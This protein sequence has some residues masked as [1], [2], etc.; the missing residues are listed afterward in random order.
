[1]SEKNV[2]ALNVFETIC[3]MFDSMELRYEK[4]VE[5]LVVT[6][7]VT[8]DDIPMDILFAVDEEMQ[9]VRL[10]SPLPGTVPEDKRADMAIVITF[11]NNML[12]N[13]SFDLDLSDGKIMFRLTQSYID[14]ILGNGMFAYMF[15]ASA[16]L[17][18]EYNDKFLMLAKGM[19]TVDQFINSEIEKR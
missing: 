16:K 9:L 19:C 2:M 8:G 10:V 6:C 17:I 5:N 7:T 11:V 13:G 3:S 12:A 14:S 18:D 4:H 15:M 1:M